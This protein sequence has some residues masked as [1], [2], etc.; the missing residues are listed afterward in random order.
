MAVDMVVVVG[1]WAV[2]ERRSEVTEIKARGLVG[3]R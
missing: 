1:W 2:V 3:H